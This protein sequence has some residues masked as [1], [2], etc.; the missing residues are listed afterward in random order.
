MKR[1]GTRPVPTK[2]IVLLGASNLTRAFPTIVALLRR[3][4]PEPLDILA[5]IG[6]GRS[7]GMRTTVGVRS[8]PGIETCDLWPA[9][10]GRPKLPTSALITDLGND[11]FYRCTMPDIFRWVEHSLDRLAAY[12]ARLA[13]SELPVLNLPSVRPWQYLM[14]RSIIFPGC[15]IPFPTIMEHAHELNRWVHS[16]SAG[17]N[18]TLLTHRA[19][20]YGFD[21]IHILRLH[22]PSAWTQWLSRLSEV[23]AHST[24]S[25]DSPLHP[26]FNIYFQAPARRWL[27]GHFQQ[28]R[29]PSLKFADG[30]QVSFF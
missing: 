23:S 8:L 26:S 18:L 6:H 14:L 17:R 11:L 3:L 12:D 10:A 5:A 7:Y 20:W 25:P 27:L 1:V 24:P 2:R 22:W 21:P 4:H 30:T 16:T 19:E 9:L 15:T 29:Q 28:R 13:I